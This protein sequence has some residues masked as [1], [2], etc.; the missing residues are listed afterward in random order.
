MKDPRY[1]GLEEILGEMD[2]PAGSSETREVT[3]GRGMGQP[4]AATHFRPGETVGGYPGMPV[5]PSAVSE[6][7]G[8]IPGREAMDIGQRMMRNRDSTI[9]YRE[10]RSR[11]PGRSVDRRRFGL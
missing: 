2:Y 9:G 10:D 8:D 1:E 6:E 3:G 4:G 5:S 11:H 7:L